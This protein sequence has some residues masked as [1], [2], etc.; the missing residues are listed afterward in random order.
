MNFLTMPS[1]IRTI[2]FTLTDETLIRF[3]GNYNCVAVRSDAEIGLSEFAD[4]SIGDSGVLKCKENESVIY[5]NLLHNY[6]YI[7]GTSGANIEILVGNNLPFNP[8]KNGGK[9]GDK[10][11]RYL[12]ITTTQLTDGA[13][14]NP[15][16]IN[17]KSVTA[18]EA[19]WAIYESTDFIFN[20]TIWQ[21]VGDL[22]NYYT[23]SETDNLLSTKANS[24]DVYTKAQADNTFIKSADI[25]IIN[26]ATTAE[27]NNSINNIWG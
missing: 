6:I 7:I 18:K 9:G 12:G 11:L 26:T 14:T 24:A 27:I 20:G 13:T 8:F 19:D 15:I 5:P 23:K 2:T 25:T 1:G 21:Q 16:I 22:S 3:S 4:K 17:N 10:L